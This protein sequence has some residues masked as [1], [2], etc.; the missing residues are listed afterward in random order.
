VVVNPYKNLPI[1][2]DEIIETYKGKKRHEMPAHVF[3]V[4]DNAYRAMLTER[5]DQSIMFT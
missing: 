3:A 5:E 1:Y 2:T 4:A